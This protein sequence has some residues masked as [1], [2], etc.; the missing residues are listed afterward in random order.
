MAGDF[1]IRDR[2]RGLTGYLNYVAFVDEGVI[3]QKDGAFLAGFLYV[4]PDLDSAVAEEIIRL[5]NAVNNA[6]T[7]LG[8]NYTVHVNAI[9]RDAAGYPES[10]FF[11][12]EQP[13]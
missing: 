3:M 11:R 13:G 9:R 12:T 6:F 4:G 10:G 5:S 1:D 7:V 8:D 2:K